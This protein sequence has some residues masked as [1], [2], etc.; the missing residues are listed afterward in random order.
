MRATSDPCWALQ[1]HPVPDS[2]WVSGVAAEESSRLVSTSEGGKCRT[3]GSLPPPGAWRLSLTS[4]PVGSAARAESQGIRHSL[5]SLFCS[6][7][8][9]SILT[10]S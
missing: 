9:E 5:A 6:I 4:I 10:K 3:A 7:Q 1:D 8:D 2:T